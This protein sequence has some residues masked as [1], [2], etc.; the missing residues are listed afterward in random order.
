M[1][2]KVSILAGLL[3]LSAGCA[4]MF[5][6]MPPLRAEAYQHYKKFGEY[7]HVHVHWNLLRQDGQV[8]ADGYWDTTAGPKIQ[9]FI[10]EMRLVGVDAE[11]RVVNR[12]DRFLPS[13]SML[14]EGNQGTFRV[15][16][17]LKGSE[18][19]FDI[20][21]DYYWIYP[22]REEGNGTSTK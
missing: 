15:A 14:E 9:V 3:L 8:I 19:A 7:G 16:M 18:A 2:R 22:G 17:P 20:E 10:K 6:V 11:R 4:D 13:P 1:K 5:K 21:V 12:S